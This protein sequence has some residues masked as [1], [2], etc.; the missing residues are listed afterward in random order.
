MEWKRMYVSRTVSIKI[1]DLF[2][3]KKLIDEGLFGTVSEFIQVAVKK[4]LQ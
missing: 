1:A 4:Q 2:K 3:I